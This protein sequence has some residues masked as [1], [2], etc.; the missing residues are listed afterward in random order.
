MRT[1]PNVITPAKRS[2]MTR[3]SSALLIVLLLLT[4]PA[5]G[6]AELYLPAPSSPRSLRND[7]PSLPY[8]EIT[9]N[10]LADDAFPL[11]LVFVG[12]AVDELTNAEIEEAI[13]G[14][15]HTWNQVPCSFAKLLWAGFRKDRSELKPDL[16]SVEFTTGQEGFEDLLAWTVRPPPGAADQQRSIH[17]NY[18][19][20][21]WS[22]DAHPFEDLQTTARPTLMLQSVLTHE[23][24]HLLG[25]EHSFAHRAATMAPAYLRDGS[26]IELSADDKIGLCHLYPAPQDE[27]ADHSDCPGDC[28]AAPQGAVCDKALGEVGQ[29]C[30][31]ELQHCPDYC[32][33]D[34][35]E[36]GI[37][38][39]SK[40]CAD[41]KDCPKALRCQ[42]PENFTTSVCVFDP[43][44]TIAQP[45]CTTAGDPQNAPLWILTALIFIVARRRPQ[46]VAHRP[47]QPR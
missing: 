36:L 22:T 45:S 26:Q 16:I 38:Y 14:A 2:L 1:P 37:G 12:E 29:Y 10:P 27:C 33:L 44:P 3:P 4:S 28:I 40:A 8:F 34:E 24:G 21:R 41:D 25:L 6:M 9:D 47:T 13:K 35:P 43:P 15:A 46:P 17:L 18:P 39:C 19:R 23:F 11:E 30:G 7:A 32:H 20:Y 31:F 5:E 42:R